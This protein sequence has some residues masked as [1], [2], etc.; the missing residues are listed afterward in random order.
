M[1]RLT[2]LY[3][4][5]QG[6]FTDNYGRLI[7]TGVAN[8]LIRTDT[9]FFNQYF[10]EHELQVSTMLALMDATIVRDKTTK[11]EITLFN[12]HEKYG[13][14]E[15]FEN[16]EFIEENEDGTKDY[17]DFTEKDRRSFQD[18]LHALNKKMHGVYNNFDKAASSRYSLGRLGMMYRKHMYPGYMRRFQKYRFDEELGDGKEGFYRTFNKTLIRD[19]RNYKLGV[20]KQWSTYTPKEKAAIRRVLTEIGIILSLFATIIALKSMADD[21]EELKESYVYNF[22][23]YEAVR[24][25]SETAQY[26]SP[27]DAWRT[28]KSPSA[29]LS[30]ASRAVRFSNQI[31]PWNI[32]EGYNRKQGVWE[33]GDNKAWA[34]FVKLIG[35]PGYNINPRRSDTGAEY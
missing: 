9:L 32:T 10:G 33:K 19:L 22:I 27:G 18:R 1:G 2:E 5:L 8:R 28:V 16:I 35:L 25:R 4:P 11:E 23:L 30:T 7:T 17:R 34:Y 29:A 3:E 14:R 20:A 26:I 12:A 21:D 13:V 15:A 24:M 6:D 31:L